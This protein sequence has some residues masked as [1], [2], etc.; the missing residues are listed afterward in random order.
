[1][2]RTAKYKRT[3]AVVGKPGWFAIG[4]ASNAMLAKLANRLDLEPADP[5]ILLMTLAA[6]IG[7]SVIWTVAWLLLKARRRA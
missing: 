6:A 1:M 2:N 3:V 5:T 7:I 4:W